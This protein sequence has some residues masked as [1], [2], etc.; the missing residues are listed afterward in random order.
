[1]E[2]RDTYTFGFGKN[3][4]DLSIGPFNGVDNRTSPVYELW[5]G[6]VTT[7]LYADGV[8][9]RVTISTFVLRLD[10]LQSCT[11]VQVEEDRC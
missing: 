11:D 7:G 8:A 5:T 1:M 9:I 2:E 10:L 4:F 6:V 3:T